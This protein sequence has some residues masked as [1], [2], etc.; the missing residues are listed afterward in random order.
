M[1]WRKLGAC[2]NALSQLYI[3]FDSSKRPISGRGSWRYELLG[4]LFLV[5]TSFICRSGLR[6]GDYN[7]ALV[8]GGD[9]SSA[10][11][12]N[13]SNIASWN[14]LIWTPLGSGTNGSI[15]TFAVFNGDLVASGEFATAGDEVA[16]SISKWN[17]NNQPPTAIIDDISPSPAHPHE[18]VN[19]VGHGA[20]IDGTVVGYSWRSSIQGQLSIQATFQCDSLSMG[21]HV[22]YFMVMDDDSTWSSEDSLQL[23]VK[24]YD[25]GF[26][27]TTD[28]WRFENNYDNMWPESW[29]SQFDY[30]HGYPYLP[31][32]RDSCNNYRPSDFPDWPLFVDAFGENQCYWDPPPG[33][34]NYMLGGL[35][36]WNMLKRSLGWQWQGSCFGF[37]VSSLLFYDNLI[38]LSDSFPAFSKVNNIVIDD[39]S[40]SFVNRYWLYQYGY[41]HQE[42]WDSVWYNVRPR[43]TLE[44]CN[45]MLSESS[46][47]DFSQ[48]SL[49][50][51]QSWRRWAFSGS[52]PY[53][54]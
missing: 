34:I 41:Y 20:D 26:R 4:R 38:S 36:R 43:Q 19:F 9:F 54:A 49:L 17:R 25:S 52:V 51:Q 53:G 40:R 47:L 24:D 32:W 10:D 33:Y 30:C 13:V 1:G 8:A 2:W 15:N 50:V 45:E 6:P 28:G 22:I 11:G 29:W 37:A 27:P 5:F 18:N 31:E 7:G 21:T 3:F 42:Y 44:Q 48:G 35:N 39:R 46:S 12:T 16:I 23:E 14:G